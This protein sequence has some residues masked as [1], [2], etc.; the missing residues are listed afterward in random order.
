MPDLREDLRSILQGC[1][2]LVGVGNVEYGDDGFGVKLAKGLESARASWAA[3]SPSPKAIPGN[4]FAAEPIVEDA[5]RSIRSSCVSQIINAGISPEH[6]L[7]FLAN[8]AFDTV[9]F[10]DAVEFGGTPGS[11]TLLNSEEMASRFPQ[12]STHRI[13]LSLLAQMI[14]ANGRT[15]VWL[16]GVQPAS[17]RRSQSLSLP[18]RETLE[19]LA[20][21]LCELYAPEE[22]SV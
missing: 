13:S 12:V 21:T 6:H 15:K 1:V 8:G 20:E 9:T 19:L 2:C 5:D 16:L 4:L 3:F 11:V 10:F 7:S 17:M 22:V 14:E 18:V